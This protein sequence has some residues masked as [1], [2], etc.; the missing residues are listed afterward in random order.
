MHTCNIEKWCFR[1]HESIYLENSFI[2]RHVVLG[3]KGC[4]LA[5]VSEH[6]KSE[7]TQ[8]GLPVK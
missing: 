3:G 1:F 4:S 2:E 7:I 5:G 8:R 6:Q